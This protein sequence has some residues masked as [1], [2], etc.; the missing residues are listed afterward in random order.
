MAY[1]GFHIVTHICAYTYTCTYTC[2]WWKELTYVPG[3]RVILFH[4]PFPND[5]PNA[6]HPVSKQGKH[7][8]EKC[9]NN[10]AVLGV[11]IQLLKETQE[12]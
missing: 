2:I 6:G 8:H 7:G 1:M 5:I 10:C 11:T 9:E 3:K 4:L 12:A